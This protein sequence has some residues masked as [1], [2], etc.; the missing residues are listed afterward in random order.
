MLVGQ[1]PVW[2]RK[3]I[4]VR[5]DEGAVLRARG[6][7]DGVKGTLFMDAPASNSFEELILLVNDKIHWK[8]LENGIPD[9]ITP[10]EHLMREISKYHF[11]MNVFTIFFYIFIMY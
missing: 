4:V 5:D 6:H 2:R 7:V 3:S 1:D 8:S 11:R 9:P 10:K